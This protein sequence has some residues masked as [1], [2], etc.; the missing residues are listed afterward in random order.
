[1]PIFYTHPEHEVTKDNENIYVQIAMLCCLLS[2]CVVVIIE[3]SNNETAQLVYYG[4]FFKLS[5]EY[6]F[7]LQM[8]KL[9]K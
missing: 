3:I 9:A 4:N 7:F 8:F 1:M 5:C 2:A 6:G